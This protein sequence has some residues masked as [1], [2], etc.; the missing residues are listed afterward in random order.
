MDELDS[1][2]A[3]AGDDRR[4]VVVGA[5]GGDDDVAQLAG[6]VSIRASSSGTVTSS[7][8][9]AAMTRVTLGLAAAYARSR[10][11]TAAS[12]PMISG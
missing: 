5:I 8:L 1:A 7:S 2:I 3:V 12:S 10:P 9:Y 11:A 4:G 6:I